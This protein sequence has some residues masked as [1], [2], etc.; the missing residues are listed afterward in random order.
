MELDDARDRADLLGFVIFL[1]PCGPAQGAV[2]FG[3]SIVMLAPSGMT[4][5]LMAER[6]SITESGGP[7]S[8]AD[9]NQLK[10]QAMTNRMNTRDRMT[11]RPA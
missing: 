4:A 3:L 9:I 11:K 7:A 6:L 1:V 10:K 5:G 8:L 2:P